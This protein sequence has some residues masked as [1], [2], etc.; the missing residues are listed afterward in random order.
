[1][2]KTEAWGASPAAQA[3]VPGQTLHGPAIPVPLLA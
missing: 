3:T 2:N 1:M